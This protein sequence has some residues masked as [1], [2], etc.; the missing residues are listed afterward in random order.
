[1]C[2]KI[3]KFYIDFF[4]IPNPVFEIKEHDNYKKDVKKS[5]N[6]F[7]SFLENNHN[8]LLRRNKW[9]E[10]LLFHYSYS[11]KFEGQWFPYRKAIFSSFYD[12]KEELKIILNDYFK[13]LKNQ[14]IKLGNELK[15]VSLFYEALSFVPVICLVINFTTKGENKTKINF[16][17]RERTVTIQLHN[18][19][20]GRQSEDFDNKSKKILKN[21]KINPE[22]LRQILKLLV[23]YSNKIKKVLET[24]TKKI[25][26]I[27]FYNIPTVFVTEKY[28]D[29]KREIPC[30][31]ITVITSKKLSSI[32]KSFLSL[33]ATLFWSRLEPFE[34]VIREL[35]KIKL[36]A[37]RSAVAAIM[38]R[39]MSHNI[40]SHVLNYLSN[41]EE[42]DSLWII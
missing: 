42:L 16:D 4:S 39:N 28:E 6:K 15:L 30:G 8:Y 36:H 7:I 27:Y 41:P 37:L 35:Y 10:I 20:N 1:M 12:D 31:G 19:E 21:Y 33:L 34:L 22:R 2:K 13:K 5:L 11:I 23:G 14:E 9:I 25:K 29:I 26:K 3:N 17:K 40:G 38:S 32:D 24:E 18:K